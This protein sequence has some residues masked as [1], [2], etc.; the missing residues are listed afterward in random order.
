[1]S[2]S[3]AQ[4]GPSH[5]RI[6]AQNIFLTYPRCDLDP[7]DA[8]EIIQ[9]KMQSHEPKYILFSRELHSDGEYHLHGLL[10]LSRQF[11]SNNPRI[12]DIGAHHPNIQSAISPK[13]VRD[14]IL[15]NPI[16]QFCIGTYVPAK[17]GRKLG[18]RFEENIRN[19]I[20]RSIISTATSKESYLSMVRKS[21]PFEWATKLSQFE[22]SASKLFP[23]VT[24]EYKSPFPT[25]SLICNENIQDWVDNTLYQP[26][27]TSRG[28]SLYICGPTR[29]GKTSWA[30]S[31][32]VHNYW[33]N[34]IDFSVYNDNAT[35]N[36]IDDI[37]FKF[38][39]CW[40]ALAGSQSDFTVNPKYGKKKRIKGGIPCI[41]LVNED[42]DWLTC[43]SSSQKT[44]FESNVV[45]YYMYA[46]EKFFN[47]VEE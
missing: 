41:I 10:Q 24:P 36:V 37:P 39:P 4:S 38:C 5:F 20:M 18:S 32:G 14:Y 27:R 46:G 15:K 1:M 31:L 30:R 19:N 3:S 12:F 17:K 8:G 25:E 44:Y 42:E 29:T 45:I 6:R 47:F 7:K 34:N 35:Y 9:S 40:K 16:T 43:M 26:N 2:S 21:F 13:S 11:S 33:Q 28:L 23:E 22:Y